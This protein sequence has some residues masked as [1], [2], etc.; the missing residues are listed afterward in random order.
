MTNRVIKN[1]RKYGES[2]NAKEAM[3]AIHQA[4]QLSDRI[5]PYDG[6]MMINKWAY[7]YLHDERL[8]VRCHQRKGF[9][10]NAKNQLPKH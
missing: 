1:K 7:R 5:D 8:H 3:G 2:H 6:S 4:M 9:L 10:P